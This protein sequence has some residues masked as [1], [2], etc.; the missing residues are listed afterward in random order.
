MSACSRDDILKTLQND[1]LRLQG[2]HSL[3][4]VGFGPL[5]EAFPNQSFPFGTI[6]E[7]I[8]I[9]SEHTASTSGFVAGMLSTLMKSRGVTVWINASGKIFPPALKSF[10]VE[11]DQFIF[12]DARREK[13][14]LWAIEESL[15]CS[16]L[17][18]VV[19]EVNE[20]DFT[21]SRR[22]QLAVERSKVTGFIIRRKVKKMTTTASMSRW[23][24][25]PLAGIPIDEALPGIGFPQWKVELLK[26]R[27]GKPG[28][29]NVQWSNGKFEPVYPSLQLLTQDQKK[30]G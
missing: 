13:D 12:F 18:A 30:A 27:N 28:T 9:H 21:T 11:P 8:N 22:F 29:W 1:I 6:H 23:R 5:L 25:T 4:T 15:K 3:N 26:M 7:F 20:L 19:G 14:I 16:A 17:S 10:H 2:F 24:I